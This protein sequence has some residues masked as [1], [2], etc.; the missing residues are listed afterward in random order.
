MVVRL[1]KS[2]AKAAK[3][4]VGQTVELQLA[5]PGRIEIRSPKIPLRLE[6]LVEKITSENRHSEADWGNAIGNEFW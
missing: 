3:L 1:P 2:L 4:K 5:G 6:E